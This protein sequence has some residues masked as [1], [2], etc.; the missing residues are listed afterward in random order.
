MSLRDG[1]GVRHEDWDTI[2][3]KSQKKLFLYSI[4]IREE[5][6]KKD[7]HLNLLFTKHLLSTLVIQFTSACLSFQHASG[8]LYHMWGG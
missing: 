1:E 6:W 8:K 7:K 3:Y 5:G 4:Y 2:D